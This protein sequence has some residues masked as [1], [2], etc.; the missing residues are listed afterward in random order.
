MSYYD[1][2]INLTGG[3]Y[4]YAAPSRADF[5]QQNTDN[6]GIQAIENREAKEQQKA[7]AERA[8]QEAELA[9]QEA[10]ANVAT[11]QQ[12][13]EAGQQ[14]LQNLK[15]QRHAD[16]A[17]AFNKFFD[18]IAKNN[19]DTMFG[20]GNKDNLL[21]IGSAKGN[22]NWLND[23]NPMAASVFAR[24]M[25]NK[26]NSGAL[27]KLITSNPKQ[28]SSFIDD[29]A[30][31][32]EYMQTV[33]KDNPQRLKEIENAVHSGALKLSGDTDAAGGIANLI[34]NNNGNSGVYGYNAAGDATA[35]EAFGKASLPGLPQ[36]SDDVNISGLDDFSPDIQMPPVDAQ[37][38]APSVNV[39]PEQ[40][41][42]APE[43]VTA[44]MPAPKAA[45]TPTP[46]AA[47]APQQA[48]QESIVDKIIRKG[49][50]YGGKAVNW[51][52]GSTNIMG[53]NI[54]NWALA[55]GGALLGGGALWG[56]NKLMS[57]PDDEEEERARARVKYA[58]ARVMRAV[59][60]T[61]GPNVP[62]RPT[63]CQCTSLDRLMQITKT[64]GQQNTY[65]G[66]H[67]MSAVKSAK[68]KAMFAV[69]PSENG[70][71]EKRPVLN[72]SSSLERLMQITKTRGNQNNNFG[73]HGMSAV[74]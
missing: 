44:N 67:G 4:K 42:G 22:L 15:Q 31:A 37:P 60:P 46:K 50:E 14:N 53:H 10:A 5:I 58:A 57:R 64:R 21:S 17:K 70:T 16:N 43:H 48:P 9:R 1:T 40:P 20:K 2:L 51:G 73:Q 66:Q 12:T 25:Q 33:N 7:D 39:T 56:L 28:V 13:A 32:Q 45:P 41:A 19:R 52:K 23:T 35:R 6:A 38:E 74:R 71:V 55:S 27:Q 3:L 65:F 68:A 29:M 47:P 8:K 11:A 63:L 24:E 34:A 62:Q 54:P 49:K 30:A 72:A 36:D 18:P 26:P 61:E 59:D 69:D